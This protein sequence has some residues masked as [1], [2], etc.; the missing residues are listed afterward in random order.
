M[1]GVT[2]NGYDV[3]ECRDADCQ[4]PIIW[5]ITQAGK[6]MPVDADPAPNG[7][8]LLQPSLN[9]STNTPRATVV[10]PNSPPLDGFDGTL[11][12]S[13]FETCPAADRWRSRKT[14]K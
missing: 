6:R 3:G 1:S 14:T 12:H 10:N 13:H 8:V 5:A 9:P 11:H 2:Y 4:A 7:N